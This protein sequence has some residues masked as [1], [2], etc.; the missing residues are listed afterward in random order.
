MSEYIFLGD[1]ITDCDH[2]CDPDGLGDGYVRFISEYVSPNHTTLNLGYDGFTIAALNRLWNRRSASLNPSH[3]SILIGINDIGVIKNTGRPLDLAFTE[4]KS[5]YETLICNIRS[6][7]DCPITLI[8]PFIFP[9]PQEFLNWYPEV[10][11][12]SQTIQQLAQEHNLQFLPTWN[13]LLEYCKIEGFHNYTTD[14][15]HLTEKGHRL[16]SHL[17]LSNKKGR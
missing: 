11:R 12:M 3:I 1:S 6:R 9:Y 17:W 2:L 7:F 16:L 5:S 8:E 13:A 10:Q 4:F 15:I 14:G